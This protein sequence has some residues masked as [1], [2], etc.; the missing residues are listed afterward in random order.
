LFK[1]VKNFRILSDFFDV[2]YR[3]LDRELL[4]ILYFL[5]ILLFPNFNL[6]NRKVNSDLHC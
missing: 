3:M 6:K 5:Y 4:N 1:S 2:T